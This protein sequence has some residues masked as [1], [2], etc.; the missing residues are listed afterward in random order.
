MDAEGV[1]GGVAPGGPAPAVDDDM[2]AGALQ[3]GGDAENVPG[4]RPI[5]AA[6]DDPRRQGSGEV[7][8]EEAQPVGGAYLEHVGSGRQRG[9]VREV[10]PDP[11]HG[12]LV[13]G[14]AAGQPGDRARGRDP[15]AGTPDPVHRV[16]PIPTRKTTRISAAATAT[17]IQLP[18]HSP[19]GGGAAPASTSAAGSGRT[20]GGGST[21]PTVS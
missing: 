14:G 19:R 1:G 12:P 2:E 21:R 16:I 18:S 5:P 17:A 3:R 8:G 13:E 15:G 9:R 10:A 7:P 11:P 6:D 4:P 20:S